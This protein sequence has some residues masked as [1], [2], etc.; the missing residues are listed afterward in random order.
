MTTRACVWKSGSLAIELATFPLAA[1]WSG[2]EFLGKV[3][4]GQIYCQRLVG[5][6]HKFT[7]R[8]ESAEGFPSWSFVSFVVKALPSLALRI[9]PPEYTC[10]EFQAKNKQGAQ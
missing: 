4:D 8:C 2:E 3:G 7:R 9:D 5:V 1:A 10:A 6:G